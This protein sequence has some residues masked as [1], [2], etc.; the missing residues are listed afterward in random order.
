MRAFNRLVSAVAFCC[1]LAAGSFP[2]AAWAPVPGTVVQEY[3]HDLTYNH[4]S[5]AERLDNGNLLFSQVGHQGPAVIEVNAAGKEL[6]RYDGVQPVCA[7]RLGNGNTLLADGGLAG[8]PRVLEVDAAGQVVWEYG[9]DSPARAPR[10]AQRLHNGNTLVTLP[11]KIIELTPDK[12]TAWSYGADGPLKPGQPGF[13]AHPVQASRLANGNTLVVDKGFGQGRVLEIT[14]GKEVVWQYGDM[15]NMAA[16]PF[17][18]A[19]D[20][21]KD[22]EPALAGPTAAERMSDGSTVI[23]DLNAK[24][25]LTVTKEGTLE[26]E[27]SWARVIEPWPVWNSWYAARDG[28]GHLLLTVTL[29]SSKS[30]VLLLDVQ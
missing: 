5:Y 22:P 9:L 12:K 15:K 2:A 23:T 30:R 11:F 8:V 28:S 17:G 3:V 24:S 27:I 26:K 4:P 19:K 13:L 20:K 16:W 1:V 10:H 14:P 21:E 29:S 18:I 7:V 6:W 25:I